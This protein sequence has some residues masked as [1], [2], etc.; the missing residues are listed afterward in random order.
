MNMVMEK[1][2]M[3]AYRSCTLCPNRCK[4]DRL[5]KQKGRCSQTS[6]V[7]VA[8]AG[9]HKGEEPPITGEK[10][11]GMIFFSGCPLMC[12]YCQNHQISTAAQPIGIEL[13]IEELAGIMLEL[14]GMGATNLNMVTGTHFIPS[15]IEALRLARSKGLELDVVWNSSG[16]ESIEGLALIDPY[17]DV[18]LIDV[19]ILD[20]DV[21]ATFCGLRRYAD[22]I[23][24]VMEFLKQ[25]HPATYVDEKGNL[26]GLLVRHL[27]FPTA[28]QASFTVLEYFARELKECAYL[29]LMVQ[30]EPPLGNASFP[31]ISEEEYD[32]LL[33]ALENLGIE[34][35][36]VQELGENVSWIPDFTQENPFP[37]DFASPLPYFLSLKRSRHQ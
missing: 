19:K 22:D 17:V 6:D 4:V 31:P 2:V 15:I 8:W 33:S 30:F 20:A 12:A 27:V 13:S 11:S 24:P 5:A 10:G 35:G 21:G 29:S 28:I 9:L 25:R 23:L 3:D 37:Q 32:A 34:E 18:Y 16:F 1:Q 14:Q 36:F 26:K 7:R